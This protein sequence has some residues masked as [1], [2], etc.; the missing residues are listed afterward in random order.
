MVGMATSLSQRIKAAISTVFQTGEEQA[1]ASA[2]L[3]FG[4]AVATGSTP[5]M[6]LSNHYR[7]TENFRGWSYVAIHAASKQYAAASV[8]VYQQQ[9]NK[10][11]G[12]APDAPVKTEKPVEDHPVLRLL[13]RPNPVF[14]GQVF[15]YQIGQQIRLT[16]GCLIW[17]VTS[18]MGNNPVELWVIPQAWCR[19][20]PATPQMPMGSYRVQPVSSSVT[21]QYYALP[22]MAG[23]NLDA[24]LV[25]RVG[26]PSPMYPGEFTSP[27]SACSMMVDIADEQDTATYAGFQNAP[28][29][30]LHINIDGTI[31][32]TQEKR[33]RLREE[34]NQRNAGSI[35]A[36]RPLVT[37][38]A[39]VTPLGASPAEL[40]Y[41]NGR[42]QSRDAMFGIQGISGTIAGVTEAQAYAALVA[43]SKQTQ[44]LSIQPDLDLIAGAFT[45]R[46]RPIY[47]DTFRVQMDAKNFDDPTTNLA[48]IQAK[49]SSGVY[50]DNE[51]R[52][53][54]G[55]PPIEGG[56]VT[57]QQKEQQA[58]E[59]ARQAAQMAAQQAGMEKPDG[60]QTEE[61]EQ[62]DPA[63][64]STQE[65]GG[66]KLTG[67]KRPDLANSSGNRLIGL[68]GKH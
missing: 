61:Q 45:H 34:L 20:Q 67:I 31:D 11:K 1:A 5:G 53:E 25:I 40:D 68:N 52:A 13:E 47:G 64:E 58:R 38:G 41:V 54:F 43:A 30:T 12:L 24:R 37:Q 57:P 62:P 56:D 10:L 21:S 46:W 4:R 3:S 42:N 8:C 14:S 17:E 49:I 63:G 55:D 66:A 6:W 7:E 39:D 22:S 23:F 27:M 16:G 19:F 33:D 59:E 50:T 32:F 15:R 2:G 65:V 36:G 18:Q 28:R 35:N 48:Y 26:W 29:P 44:E 60:S 9:A 51:I